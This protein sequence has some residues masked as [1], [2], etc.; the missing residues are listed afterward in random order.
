MSLFVTITK[1]KEGNY[2]LTF[3]DPTPP[4]GRSIDQALVVSMAGLKSIEAA[5]KSVVEG[6]YPVQVRE[7][8]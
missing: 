6:S 7:D 1:T 4:V 8:G 2:H 5:A 3:Q